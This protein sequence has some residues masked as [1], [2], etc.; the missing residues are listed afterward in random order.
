MHPIALWSIAHDR[1]R[2]LLDEAESYRLGQLAKARQASGTLPRRIR[3]AI[4]GSRPARVVIGGAAVSA[5]GRVH[6][7]GR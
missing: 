3:H 6:E 1:Q 7:L 4:G 2:S 5:S